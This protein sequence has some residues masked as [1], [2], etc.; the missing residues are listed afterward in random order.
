M[1][2]DPDALRRFSNSVYG[3]AETLSNTDVSTSFAIS[4]D[5]VQGSEFS[6]AAEA[7]FTAAMT[8][9]QHVALRLIQVSEIAK[10]SS[11]DYEVTEGDFIGMLDAMDVSE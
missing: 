4:Q 1:D 7:A 6:N 11:D 2:V 8:G 9:F 5:A 3:A 10:G